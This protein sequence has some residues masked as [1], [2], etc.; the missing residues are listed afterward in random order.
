MNNQ[1]LFTK[2]YFSKDETEIEKILKSEGLWNNPKYWRDYGDNPGNWTIIG[3]QQKSPLNALIEKCIN[4]GDSIL[5]SKC[6]EKGISPEDSINA[7]KNLLEAVETLIGVKGGDYSN[8]TPLE[9]TKIA[10]ESGGIIT[11]SSNEKENPNYTIFDFGEGQSPEKFPE[12]FMSLANSNKVKI[13]FVQGK[14]CAG[15]SG[16]MRFCKYQLILSRRNPNINAGTSGDF[17]F[18]I[19][20]TF[21]ATGVQRSP[22]VKY[23]VINGQVPSFTFSKPLQI[24]CSKNLSNPSNFDRDFSYGSIVKLFNYKIGPGLST[25]ANI[26]LNKALNRK[27]ISPAV[28]IRVYE[29]RKLGGN[30]GNTP[31]QNI[32]GLLRRLTLDRKQDLEANMPLGLS[33]KENGQIFNV[34]VYVLNDQAIFSNWHGSEGLLYSLNGQV[35]FSKNSSIYKTKKIGL[36]YLDKHIITIVDCSRLD[37]NHISQMF[38][39]NREGLSDEIFT[40]NFENKLYNELKN[41]PGLKQLAQER[42]EKMVSKKFSNGK[43]KAALFDII[44]R[45]ISSVK[46]YLKIGKPGKLAINGGNGYGNATPFSGSYFPTFFNLE[47]QFLS[48]NPK[49]AEQGRQIRVKFLTD[50]VNDFLTRNI[51]KGDF[52]VLLGGKDVT[53][54]ATFIPSNGVWILS[55]PLNN[56]KVGSVYRIDVSLIDNVNLNTLKQD[57]FI[58]VSNFIP[59]KISN[60]LKNKTI[61]PTNLPDQIM[62]YKDDEVY[63]SLGFNELTASCVKRSNIPGEYDFF[64]YS[65]NQNLN[66]M[67][68]QN[69]KK[70]KEL[71]SIYEIT[72]LTCQMCCVELDKQGKIT[73]LEDFS[74]LQSEASQ[75]GIYS[76]VILGAEM[77]I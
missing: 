55:L 72:N 48:K 38:L 35:N 40:L 73:D 21:P 16:V 70:S 17:G 12:T 25:L 15:S 65:D 29:T 51:D 53:Q 54:D 47:K 45:R 10:E 14:H 24:L 6:Q 76:A 20:R 63:K 50:K 77:K 58:K 30:G 68:N 66:N 32:H 59:K 28:P 69:P 36:E 60:S 7:P 23:L 1:Q 37:N 57:F 13:P 44:S 4:L 26:D 9:I 75:L 31:I 49:I 3:N 2:L 56:L 22:I 74:K 64:L 67:K 27:L 42:R 5:V 52:E 46:K 62:V 11:S 61:T 43:D 34:Q 41:H 18:T 33:I 39:N 8:I 19:T 71:Q